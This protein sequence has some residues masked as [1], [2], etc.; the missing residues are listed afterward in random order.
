MWI[1]VSHH[2]RLFN[3]SLFL[4]VAKI[5]F[6]SN[7]YDKTLEEKQDFSLGFCDSDQGIIA[8]KAK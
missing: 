2:T 8:I 4:N 7:S 3:C 5:F 6:G 1:K